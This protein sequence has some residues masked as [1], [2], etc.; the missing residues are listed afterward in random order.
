MKKLII[1]FG[2]AAILLVGCTFLF[3]GC[4]SILHKN[5]V[6]TETESYY[7]I[8]ADTP[9]KARLIKNGP[10]EEVRRTRDSWVVDSG[11][12]VQL[13]EKANANTFK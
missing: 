5:Y 2:M 3:T 12:L 9:F 4:A 8:P 6:L 7:F 13:Q 10:I 1:A 11:Y